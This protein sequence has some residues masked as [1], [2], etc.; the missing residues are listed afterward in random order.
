MPQLTLPS[1][2]RTRAGAAPSVRAK[3]S[4]PRPAH[5]ILARG[6]PVVGNDM[7]KKRRGGAGADDSMAG[8]ACEGGP[9]GPSGEGGAANPGIEDELERV[10]VRLKVRPLVSRLVQAT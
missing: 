5:T 8:P 9:A 2:L 10:D 3:H 4:V 1:S 7:G 6:L